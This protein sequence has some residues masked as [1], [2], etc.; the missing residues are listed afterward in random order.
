VD[1]FGGCTSPL[2][3][4]RSNCCG[5][6]CS[7]K[8]I[9]ATAGLR[10]AG[11]NTPNWSVSHYDVPREKSA[12]SA[13]RP[14]VRILWPLVIIITGPHN[15]PVLFCSRA[16]VVRRRLSSSVTLPAG[17]GRAAAGRV[18]VGRRRTG[19]VGGRAA[20]TARWASTV[21]SR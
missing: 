2:K 4:I 7:K 16:S 20:D 6:L 11:C 19:R 8:S 14:I 1:N 13:M 10:T 5:S 12:L 17:G 21:T 15:G 9:T 3:I 18:A